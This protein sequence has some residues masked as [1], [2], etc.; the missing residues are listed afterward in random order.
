MFN[1]V[2]WIFFTSFLFSACGYKSGI[3][4]CNHIGSKICVPYVQGDRKGLLT[5]QLIYA[6]KSSGLFSESEKGALTLK[7]KICKEIEQE[8]GYRQDFKNLQNQNRVIVDERRNVMI[9][10]ASLCK[11]EKVVWGPKKIRAFVDYDFIDPAS[12][13]EL[14]FVLDGERVQTVPFSLG[15]LSA[16]DSSNDAAMPSLYL[17]VAE[18]IV[19]QISLE[20]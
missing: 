6:L 13:N 5:S 1:K 15:Q 17:N 14:S 18:K 16:Q 7:V 2:L 20:W 3:G 4:D 9:V 8:I 19:D 11:C 10:E 12:L